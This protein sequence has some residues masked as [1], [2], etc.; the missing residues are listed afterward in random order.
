MNYKGKHI[1]L[2]TISMYV[3]S[4]DNIGIIPVGCMC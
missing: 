1:S 3:I 4:K 2:K